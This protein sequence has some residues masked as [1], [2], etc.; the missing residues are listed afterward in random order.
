MKYGSLITYHSPDMTNVKVFKSRSNFR[1][2]VWR[3]KIKVPIETAFSSGELKMFSFGWK[4]LYLIYIKRGSPPP[5]ITHTAIFR[6]TGCLVQGCKRRDSWGTC[7]FPPPE[8]LFCNLIK[9]RLILICSFVFML[10]QHKFIRLAFL[11][12]THK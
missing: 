3:L 9:M 7:T 12:S 4:Y 8:V 2:M 10:L 1:V 11:V 6:S 5:P